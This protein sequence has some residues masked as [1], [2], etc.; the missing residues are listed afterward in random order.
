MAVWLGKWVLALAGLA[1]AVA[2]YNWLSP[3]ETRD[4]RITRQA[5]TALA[6]AE[7]VS[8]GE[9]LDRVFDNCSD[10]CVGHMA[11]YQWA[12]RHQHLNAERCASPSRS[13]RE[14]CEMGVADNRAIAR[15]TV[16]DFEDLAGDTGVDLN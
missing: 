1:A 8:A 2:L 5:E 7:F 10:G 6:R 16:R 13:F 9:N 3:S 14:G 4:Q 12:A 11:G 15:A